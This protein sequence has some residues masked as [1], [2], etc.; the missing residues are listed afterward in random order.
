[1]WKDRSLKSGWRF[2]VIVLY[3]VMIGS[4]VL[5]IFPLEAGFRNTLNVVQV[6][7]SV[8]FIVFAWF[9]YKKPWLLKNE[10]V[11]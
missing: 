4:I 8:V 5:R 1:M 10:D 2:L 11:E 9:Y 7:A 6:L 3:V